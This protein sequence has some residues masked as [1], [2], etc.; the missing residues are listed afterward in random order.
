MEVA[1][2][3]AWRGQR[4]RQMT[5]MEITGPHEETP[6]HLAWKVERGKHLSRFFWV[7]WLGLAAP[8]AGS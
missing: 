3:E 7:F 6:G 4:G 2:I 8:T 5:G 1:F